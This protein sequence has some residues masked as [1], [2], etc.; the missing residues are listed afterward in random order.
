MKKTKL[1]YVL[2]LDKDFD[3]EHFDDIMD[4]FG[5]YEQ[6]EGKKS[7][8]KGRP[9]ESLKFANPEPCGVNKCKV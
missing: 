1:C 7:K 5:E 6:E 2:F 3:P 4:N 9:K 8:G